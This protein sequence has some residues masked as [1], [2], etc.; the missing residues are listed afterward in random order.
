MLD[1]IVKIPTLEVSPLSDIKKIKIRTTQNSKGTWW[2]N[3]TYAGVDFF[4]E[5][6]TANEVNTQMIKALEKKGFVGKRIWEDPK[7]YPYF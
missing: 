2:C 3:T 1:H 5:G 4:F 6:D 7:F